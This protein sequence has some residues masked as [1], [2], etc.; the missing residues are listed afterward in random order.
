MAI[1]SLNKKLGKKAKKKIETFGFKTFIK[2]PCINSCSGV[3][4]NSFEDDVEI[5]LLTVNT[6]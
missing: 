2:N 1:E 3:F 5:W 6:L 4:F